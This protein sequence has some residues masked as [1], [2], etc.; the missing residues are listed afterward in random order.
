MLHSKR[1]QRKSIKIK[2]IE[3]NQDSDLKQWPW[4]CSGVSGDLQAPTMVPI[5]SGDPT[6]PKS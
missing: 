2:E 5:D 3:E 6:M 4:W 1:N